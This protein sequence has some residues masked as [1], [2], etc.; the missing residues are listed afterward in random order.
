MSNW[1]LSIIGSSS[2]SAIGNSA[3]RGNSGECFDLSNTLTDLG[4]GVVGGLAGRNLGI[5]NAVGLAQN[6]ATF[7][8][9]FARGNGVMNVSSGLISHGYSQLFAQ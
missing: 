9:A 7:G 6:G 1:W 8:T 4:T 2:V 5:A 3:I